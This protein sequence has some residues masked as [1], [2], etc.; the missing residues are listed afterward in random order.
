MSH[1]QINISD[2]TGLISPEVNQALIDSMNVPQ[3]RADNRAFLDGLKGTANLSG[4]DLLVDMLGL[5]V[6]NGLSPA[7]VLAHRAQFGT[8]AMPASPKTSY[9]MLLFNALSDTTLLI[10]IAA[11][12]V[13]LGIGYWKDPEIGWITG[14]AIFIAV[15]LVSNISAGNNYSKELQFRALQ[16]SSQQDERASVL[17]GGKVELVNPSELVVG[18][19]CVL[20]VSEVSMIIN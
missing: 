4:V 3:G 1:V 13:S 20:Q 12:C 10:L 19:I 9:L 11:A 14:T 8:N 5:N 2:E 6:V 16:A 15:F 18:D 17:R 7:K